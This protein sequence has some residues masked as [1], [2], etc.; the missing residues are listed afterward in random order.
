[1]K[2]HIFKNGITYELRGEYYYPLFR[3]P[4]NEDYPIGKYGNLR[5]EFLKQ[6]PKGTYN[7]LLTEF[8]L[9]KH[10]HDIDEEAR[11]MIEE[12]TLRIVSVR[13]GNEEL[14]AS[15]PLRWVQEMRNAKAAAEEI[16]LREVVYR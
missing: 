5:H 13:G 1:M 11:Q 15:D 14:K 6:H 8:T 16:V 3:L 10:L 9:Q 4:E 2:K 7:T 12:L